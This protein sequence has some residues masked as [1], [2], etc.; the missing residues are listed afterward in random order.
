[1]HGSLKEYQ[2]QKIMKLDCLPPCSKFLFKKR[3]KTIDIIFKYLA[4]KQNFEFCVNISTISETAD[5]IGL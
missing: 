2:Q 5:F 4:S 1:M 3:A